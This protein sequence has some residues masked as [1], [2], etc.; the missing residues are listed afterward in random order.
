MLCEKKKPE[1]TKRNKCRE[2]RSAYLKRSTEVPCRFYRFYQ[3]EITTFA[4]TGNCICAHFNYWFCMAFSR[5]CLIDINF[6]CMHGFCLVKYHSIRRW[7]HDATFEKEKKS[8]QWT[9]DYFMLNINILNFFVCVLLM[10]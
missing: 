9:Q 3:Y 2:K 5:Q 7:C 1:K 6:K 10:K 4:K 8:L